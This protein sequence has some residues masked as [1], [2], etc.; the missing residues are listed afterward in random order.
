MRSCRHPLKEVTLKE[1]LTIEGLAAG[2]ALHPLQEAFL[3]EEALQ[4]GLCTP[5]MILQAYS[6]LRKN[7]RPTRQQVFAAMDGNLCRCGS[8]GRILQAID[9]AA[10]AM[11]RG[12]GR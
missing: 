3:R 7:P 6:L 10:E 5:G 4:C 12:S 2:G 8:Y 1:V 11:R 9:A